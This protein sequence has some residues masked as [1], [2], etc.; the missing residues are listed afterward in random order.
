MS[1]LDTVLQ[2]NWVVPT[3]LVLTGDNRLVLPR[4]AVFDVSLA[5]LVTGGTSFTFPNDNFFLGLNATVNPNTLGSTVTRSFGAGNSS[6]TVTEGTNQSIIGS[7]TSTVGGTSRNLISASENSSIVDTTG[8][9]NN[10]E[11]AIIACQNE[12]I[13]QTGT[14]DVANNFIAASQNCNLTPNGATRDARLNVILGCNF[15]VMSHGDLSAMICCDASFFNNAAV[16]NARR[17]LQLGTNNSS[18]QQN[19][20]GTIL[21][22][23]I[24]SR[25]QGATN[26]L[27]SGTTARVDFFSNVLAFNADATASN[28]AIF[29]TRMDVTGGNLMVTNGYTRSS[30]GY[31]GN[32][33]V[34]TTNT[35]LLATDHHVN[36]GPTPGTT[37][38]LTVPSA[39]SLSASFPIGT[40][41]EFRISTNENWQKSSITSTSTLNSTGLTT[42]EFTNSAEII[43]LFFYNLSPTPYYRLG[44]PYRRYIYAT[45]PQNS[46]GISPPKSDAA[47]L[48]TSTSQATHLALTTTSYV[49]FTTVSPASLASLVSGLCQ[50]GGWRGEILVKYEVQVRTATGGGN[51]LIRSDMCQSDG[52]TWGGY[53]ETAGPN[54]GG[55]VMIYGEGSTRWYSNT[56]SLT[57]RISQDASNLINASANIT[58]AR[59]IIQT[60]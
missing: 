10:S 54:T 12:N 28:Q 49:T 22:G 31:L 13:F 3:P 30:N 18:I 39:A 58:Y 51:F 19:S 40:V 23:C 8:T 1:S 38:V 48:P 34:S 27:L 37:V 46:F 36:L 9:G 26:C 55:S 16:S 14:G 2:R 53:V 44:S 17:C 47:Q 59:L 56:D 20:T 11:N 52:T 15:G 7:T 5:T 33:R 32:F 57:I 35:T 41:K 4:G 50:V 42:L 45:A 21:L 6:C 29:G 60:L 24:N 43:T 25:A